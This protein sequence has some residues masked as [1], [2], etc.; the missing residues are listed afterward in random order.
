MGH[1]SCCHVGPG[2]CR[3]VASGRCHLP[4]LLTKLQDHAD[5]PVCSVAAGAVPDAHAVG[6]LACAGSWSGAGHYEWQLR[7]VP[8]S[9][10]SL[11]TAAKLVMPGY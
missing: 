3:S 1:G 7:L 8:A 9:I 2:H 6:V 5:S 10:V 4:D 11:M